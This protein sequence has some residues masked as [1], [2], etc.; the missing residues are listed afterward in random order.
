MR[1]AEAG[2]GPRV[3]IVIPVYNGANYLRQA[4]DS[5][6][7]QTYGNVEVVVVDDGSTDG[8]QTERIA[9][10]YGDRIRYLQKTNGG[11][12]TALNAGIEAMTGDFFSWLSHDDV[13]LPDKVAAQVEAARAAGPEPVVVYSAYEEIDSAGTVLRNSLGL[14]RYD[15]PAL[16]V[17]AT[18]IH[19]CAMLIPRQCFTAVGTFNVEMETT[20]DA[21]MWLRFVLAGFR[22][23][24]LPRV[25]IQSRQHP[26]Q[27]SHTI[28]RHAE[29]CHR[30]FLWAVD[31]LGPEGRAARLGGL[32]RVL[33]RKDEI[34]AFRQLVRMT[35][36][37]QGRGRALGLVARNAPLLAA[38]SVRRAVNPL[39]RGPRRLLRDAARAAGFARRGALHPSPGGR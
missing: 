31:A 37:E 3:S 34:G 30:W 18:V 22:F 23:E 36:A 6:L 21:E 14:P 12:A 29:N 24:Y 26:E 8:G 27:G 2:A 35:A 38:R 32:P 7:A 20:P 33:L 4:I 17:F 19:G 28:S 25:L 15:D 1:G 16:A 39:V 11:V 9:R 10:G 5:A 13:Y